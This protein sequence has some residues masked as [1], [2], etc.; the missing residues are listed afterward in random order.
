MSSKFIQS[1]PKFKSFLNAHFLAMQSQSFYYEHS[2]NFIT[3][4]YCPN[5]ILMLISGSSFSVLVSHYTP[6]IIP[7][8]RPLLH[9]IVHHSVLPSITSSHRASLRPTVHYFIPPS[10]I[11]V[12]RPLLHPPSIH[13]AYHPSLRPVHH[14]IMSCKVTI[15]KL[16]PGNGKY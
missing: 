13:L 9:P 3:R 4:T 16:F 5:Y 11:P 14:S 7:A 15:V 8:Y 10:I 1:P 2:E 6:S 12:H